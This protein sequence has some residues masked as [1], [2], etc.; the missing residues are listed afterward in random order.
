MNPCFNGS[1]ISDGRQIISD[2]DLYPFLS[3]YIKTARHETHMVGL[4]PRVW[5]PWL[6]NI[7]SILFSM[8]RIEINSIWKSNH[9]LYLTSLSDL[10][11]VFEW[12]PTHCSVMKLK[13]NTMDFIKILHGSAPLTDIGTVLP[14]HLWGN[15]CSVWLQVL[16]NCT[17]YGR[18]MQL[19]FQEVF[20]WPVSI[21]KCQKHMTWFVFKQ[22]FSACYTENLTTIICN[23]KLVAKH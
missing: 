21:S 15:W 1:L 9:I 16:L 12:K 3:R 8:T 11:L 13:V 5:A 4:R 6:A 23:E 22:K 18:F 14:R 20:L 7:N 2:Q 19:C 10:I 17:K